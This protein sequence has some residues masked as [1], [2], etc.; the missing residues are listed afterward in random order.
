MPALCGKTEKKIKN[1]LTEE[2][3]QE[4]QNCV[5]VHT[6]NAKQKCCPLQRDTS[7]R[8]RGE[9]RKVDYRRSV[10]S[11]TKGSFEEAMVQLKRDSR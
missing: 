9:E 11:W 4:S 2:L 6:S 10:S 8:R 1:N 3:A 7:E 5:T